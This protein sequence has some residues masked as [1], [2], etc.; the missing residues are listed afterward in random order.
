MAEGVWLEVALNGPWTRQRQPGI[1]VTRAEI[2]EQA[3]ACADAGAAI[4]HLHAYDEGSGRPREAYDLYA[5]VFEAIRNRRDVICYPTVPMG[6]RPS[7]GPAEART[8]YEVVE[9]LGRA[10]LIEWSV[11]DPGSVT[12]ATFAELRDGEDGFLYANSASDV[13]IGLELCGQHGLVPSYAVYEPGFLR[14]GA[15]LRAAVPDSPSPVYRF[16]FST[17][18]TF[19]LPP[20]EWALD[21]YLR[22]LGASDP[23]APWMI[24]GLGVELDGLWDAAMAGGGHLRVGLEDAPPGCTK[25]NAEMVAEACHAVQQ[26]GLPLATA[27]EVRRATVGSDPLPSARTRR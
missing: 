8:R 13:R 2:V 17:A 23:G 3:V 6:A 9:E 19:G 24:A 11:V 26:A 15:A 16:M 7:Q 10:G 14:T 21:S 27:A 18:F 4:V 12:L 20:T 22:L 25:T 1:P 5:P